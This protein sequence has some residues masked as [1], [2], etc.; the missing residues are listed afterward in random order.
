VFFVRLNFTVD[1]SYTGLLTLECFTCHM[2]KRAC[3]YCIVYSKQWPGHHR[4]D[5][6]LLCSIPI[7][8]II[9]LVSYNIQ[10]TDLFIYRNHH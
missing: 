4:F 6:R 1:Y 7:D 5:C 9:Y 3:L 10:H 8:N 2:V